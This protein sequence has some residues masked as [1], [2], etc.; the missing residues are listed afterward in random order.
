LVPAAGFYEWHRPEGGSRRGQPYFVHAGQGDGLLAFAGLFEV[1]RKGDEPLTTFTIL[2]TSSASGLEFLHD[3]SPVVVGRQDWSR[4]LDPSRTD[5]AS[6]A[7]LL[8]PAGSG[9]LSAYPVGPAVG[10]VRNQGPELMEPVDLGVS[11]TA[12]EPIAV[13]PRPQPVDLTLFE[14]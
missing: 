3:R 1:W 4:W 13:V 6:L 12:G 7:D 8:V 2:T 10:N 9:V 11:G 14:V 5:A